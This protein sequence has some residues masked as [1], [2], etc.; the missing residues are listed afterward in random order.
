[1]PSTLPGILGARFRA[2]PLFALVAHEDL[3]PPERDAF[4][5][6]A[7]RP[8]H[9]G[10]LIASTSVALSTKVV[11]R[12]TAQLLTALETPGPLPEHV[13]SAGSD[14][15]T[16]A[17]IQLVMDGVLEIETEAGFVSGPRAAP[18]LRVSF[19]NDVPADEPRNTLQQ[20][21]LEALELAASLPTDSPHELASAMYRYNTLP[22]SP[23][24]LRRFT[25]ADSVLETLGLGA[26]TP[27]SELLFETYEE[28]DHPSW[29]TWTRLDRSTAPAAIDLRFK[30]YVSVHPE[31]L[32]EA[33]G[34]AINAFIEANVPAFK[35]VRSAAGLLRP[36]KL[37]AYVEDETALH[38]LANAVRPIL[39]GFRPHGVP[40]SCAITDDGLLSWGSD[41]PTSERVLPWQRTESW[42]SWITRRLALAIIQANAS[43]DSTMTAWEFALERLR[44]ENVDTNRWSPIADPWRVA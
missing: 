38:R 11:G 36:D 5:E 19:G 32:A 28:G 27:L 44:L 26:T 41:P 2:S 25:Q 23:R 37:I 8:D 9:F 17:L 43:A 35:L 20:L 21:S 39:D 31:S 13:R 24:W 42:R 33:T 29:Y 12:D 7:S 34:L 22:L 18:Y 3:A 4:Q 16:T 6:L 10:L 15:N 1:V 40:F 14:E 30:L